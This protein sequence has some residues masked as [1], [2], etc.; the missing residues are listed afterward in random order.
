MQGKSSKKLGPKASS[1][2]AVLARRY[3]LLT[4]KTAQSQT[5]A[6]LFSREAFGRRMQRNV[7]KDKGAP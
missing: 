6:D 2:N 1:K 3:E 4:G 5:K 7:M